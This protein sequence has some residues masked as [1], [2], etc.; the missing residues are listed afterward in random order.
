MLTILTPFEACR[1]L[2]AQNDRRQPLL[3]VS[4]T[5]LVAVTRSHQSKLL[6]FRCSVVTKGKPTRGPCVF[7]LA[8]IGWSKAWVERFQGKQ[9]MWHRSED[10][11]TGQHV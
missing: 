2:Q 9:S 7:V 6:G 3:H 5:L 11:G 8:K 10:T 4:R 1:D